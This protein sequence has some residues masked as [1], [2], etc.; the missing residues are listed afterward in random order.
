MAAD[1]RRLL[2]DAK[3]RTDFVQKAVKKLGITP[4]QAAG[5][6]ADNEARIELICETLDAERRVAVAM[7]AIGLSVVGAFVAKAFGA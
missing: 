2:V 1:I 5:Y 4:Q 3:S 7:Y 6:W